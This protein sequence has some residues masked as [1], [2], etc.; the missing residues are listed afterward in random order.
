MVLVP[1]QAAGAATVTLEYEPPIPEIEPEPAYTLV[2]EAGPGEANRLR[3]AQDAGGFVVRETGIAL[4]SAGANC[5]AAAPGQVRCGVPAG[6]RHVSVFVDAGDGADAVALGPLAGLDVAEVVAG[7]GDD[8]IAGHSGPDLLDVGA[9]A[10]A[11]S[12]G[13][14]NDRIDGGG[15]ADI[16]DGGDGR[17]LITYASHS[18]PVTADLAAGRGGSRGQRDWLTG[19]ED[20]A[21]GSASDRLFGDAGSNLLYGGLGGRRDS[22]RGRGGDDT[23]TLRGRAVGGA[24]DDVLDSERVGCGRGGDVAFRQRFRP[25][26]PYRRA[27]ERVRR[28]FYVLTRPR[29]VGRKLVLR[30]A[31]PIRA[32]RGTVSLRD[33]RG[34]LGSARYAAD[35]P[36]YGGPR[37]LRVVAKLDRRPQD[38]F[39]RFEITGRSSARDSF[40]LRLD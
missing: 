14:G 24:G 10:D 3:I 17:D 25:P 20:V 11:V 22:G 13:P 27:C 26:G 7:S 30:F 36:E 6:A 1:A 28:F 29:V 8:L 9:G 39:G 16:L 31:C 33:R 38:Q 4:L 37:A 19:F 32:C 21:G 5:A 2:V 18:Q 40:R 23:I 12:G 34:R 35:H 15:G